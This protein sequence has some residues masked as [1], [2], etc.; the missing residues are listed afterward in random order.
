MYLKKKKKIKET[1]WL[2]KSSVWCLYQ[3]I[4]KKNHKI[5]HAVNVFAFTVTLISRKKLNEPER[6]LDTSFYPAWC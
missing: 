2:S 4:S 6:G 3:S 5:T 1:L